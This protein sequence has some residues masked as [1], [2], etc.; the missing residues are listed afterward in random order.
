MNSI[1][2]F[3]SYEEA[4]KKSDKKDGSCKLLTADNGCISGCCSG[5]SVNSSTEF[6]TKPGAHEDQEGF[7]VLEGEGYVKLDDEVYP[8]KKGDSFIALPGVKHTIKTNDS[9]VP[10]KVFWFHSSINQ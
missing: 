7:F 4:L 9:N 8:I 10:V 3:I 1:N 5:I 2:P 6:S